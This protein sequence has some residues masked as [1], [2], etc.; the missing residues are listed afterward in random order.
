MQALTNLSK[1][2]AAK[3]YFNV[4]N[5]HY[6]QTNGQQTEFKRDN[7]LVIKTTETLNL[8]NYTKFDTFVNVTKKIKTIGSK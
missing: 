6:K 7:T 4:N 1:Q 2:S 3:F 5:R 8:L